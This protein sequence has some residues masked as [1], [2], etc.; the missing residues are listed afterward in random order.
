MRIACPFRWTLAYST[1]INSSAFSLLSTGIEWRFA[2]VLAEV[3]YAGLIIR[4]FRIKL[5]FS[6]FDW[7]RY[8]FKYHKRRFH[9]K[10]GLTGNTLLVGIS[11]K[12][13]STCTCGL[14]IKCG[15]DGKGTTWVSA[16]T[17]INTSTI[18]ASL[19]GWTHWVWCT[20]NINRFSYNLGVSFTKYLSTIMFHYLLI[21]SHLSSPLP[22]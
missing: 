17:W 21:S 2:R 6:N 22:V 14:V 10:G 7:K 18:D 5:A 15:A 13:W 3:L 20:T 9:L 19:C 11:S 4:T 1:M 12:T 8:K 16:I